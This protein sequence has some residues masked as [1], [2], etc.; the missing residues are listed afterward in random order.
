MEVPLMI[1]GRVISKVVSTR[2]Y[3]S[4]Q[5]FKLL[6]IEPCNGNKGDYFIAADELGAGEGELVIVTRGYSAHH[7][8]N[9]EAPIDAVVVGIVDGEPSIVNHVGENNGVQA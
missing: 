7:A 1:L 8:L 9:R 2:K 6:V 3:D 4:L 5:G